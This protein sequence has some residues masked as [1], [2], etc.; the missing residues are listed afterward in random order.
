MELIVDVQ[1]FCVPHFV[2]KEVVVLSRDGRR[3]LH[4]IVLRQ[5]SYHELDKKKK[6]ENKLIGSTTII[7]D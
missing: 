3:L 2:D 5:C 1:G 6:Q 7:M 4:L